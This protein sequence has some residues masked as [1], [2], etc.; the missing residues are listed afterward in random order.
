MAGKEGGGRTGEDQCAFC[1]EPPVIRSGSGERLCARHLTADIERRVRDNLRVTRGIAPGDHVAVALSGG[2]DSS[3]MLLI[4]NRILGEWADASITAITIDEGIAGYRDGTIRAACSLT[5]RLGVRHH[6]TSFSELFGHDLDHFLQGR[7]QRACTICGVLRRRALADAARSVGAARIA[8]GH[9]LDDEAQSVLMNILRGDLA[10]LAQDS[11]TGLPGCFLPRIKP[12]SVISEREVFT[13]LLVK[14]CYTDL[15][16]CPYARSA[17]RSE[18]RAMLDE[19]EYRHPGTRESLIRSRDAIR[20][21]VGPAS[22]PGDLHA[23]QSCGA[24]CSGELCQACRTLRSLG[25]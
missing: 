21:Q 23:C 6:V 4:L 12:L 13:Y 15:P 18:V 7:E 1:P 11:T 2:K 14:G 5:R 19:L 24:M 8:T 3:C 25:I 9:N 20:K 22:L 16:E 10:R 17:L